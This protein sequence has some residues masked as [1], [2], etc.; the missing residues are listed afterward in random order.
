MVTTDI[1][2]NHG[3]CVVQLYIDM[4]FYIRIYVILIS[5]NSHSAWNSSNTWVNN[6]NK[7]YFFIIK[8][9]IGNK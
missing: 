8:C 7:T 6:L 5:N 3:L 1:I 4:V 2:K 9:I